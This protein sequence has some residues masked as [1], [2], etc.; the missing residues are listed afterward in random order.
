MMRKFLRTLIVGIAFCIVLPSHAD[1][2]QTAREIAGYADGKDA[3]RWDPMSEEARQYIG[4]MNSSPSELFT[5][6]QSYPASITSEADLWQL[7]M[8]MNRE[9]NAEYTYDA[10]AVRRDDN[11]KKWIKR[12]NKMS[13]WRISC[14][15]WREK[16]REK[17]T[18]YAIFS[19]DMRAFAAFRNPELVKKLTQ[20]ERQMLNSCCDW[21]ANNI[22]VGMPN[23][24]KI[25]KV[26][27]AVADG[28]TYTTGY[29]TSHDI[30]MK[31][32]GVCAAYTT[33]CQLLLHMLKIDCRYAL[34]TVSTSKTE[35]HAWNLVDVNGEWF[36]MDTTWDDPGFGRAYTYFLITD[37]EM[38]MDHEWPLAGEDKDV[39]PKTPALNPHH[40]HMR[41]YASLA[42]GKER[43][44]DTYYTDDGCSMVE[45]LLEALPGE[46][47]TGVPALLPE[48]PVESVVQTAREIEDVGRK[49]LG[50]ERQA[51]DEKKKEDRVST[52]EDLNKLLKQWAETLE[53]PRVTFSMN[54]STNTA[55]DMLNA[56]DIHRYVRRYSVTSSEELPHAPNPVITVTVEY[57]PHVRLVSAIKNRDAEVR[58]TAD[59]RAA[60]HACRKLA[61][62]FG[63]AW[64]LERQKT[65]DAYEYLTTRVN[66][67]DRECDATSALLKKTSSSLGYATTL[68]VLC[69]LMDI[70]SSVVHGRT[71]S[72]LHEWN[73]VR[74]A[75]KRWFHADAGM[76]A[77]ED[78][79]REHRWK[80]Y[81]ECDVDFIDDHVWYLDEHPATPPGN[82]LKKKKQQK[83]LERLRR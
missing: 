71:D 38:R 8:A 77:R 7:L 74:R 25:K 18:F 29:Y 52:L 55:R 39:Y 49:L 42:V 73:M 4:P 27:D 66:W 45:K 10:E 82:P 81:M 20:P 69:A 11:L 80:Y 3:P 12:I 78:N 2:L 33:A 68:H 51:D 13:T 48:Q 54:G 28:T 83:L 44:A 46:N 59:E 17:I 58:L 6:S 30:I 31:G 23:L 53:G 47:G 22:R 43:G 63:A 41:H 19:S 64:K 60:L 24:L 14:R 75:G 32:K 16:N 70:P 67:S 21:I 36:H 72:E 37:E 15:S 5:I 35:T 34:G 56:S 65:R 50:M 57:W 62:S 1:S 26:H 76:D 9:L 40:F 61:E 79:R